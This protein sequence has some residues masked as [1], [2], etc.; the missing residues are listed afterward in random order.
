[1]HLSIFPV[2][3]VE[4]H[5]NRATQAV[6]QLLISCQRGKINQSLLAGRGLCSG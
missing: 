4:V 5:V 2:T 1:M 6:I 3:Q